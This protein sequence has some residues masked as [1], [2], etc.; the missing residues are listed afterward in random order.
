MLV[1]FVK[2][3]F[4]V[5]EPSVLAV[6]L[7]IQGRTLVVERLHQAP[8]IM[9]LADLVIVRLAL[10]DV[11]PDAEATLISLPFTSLI[12]LTMLVLSEVADRK[13]VV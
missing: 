9:N 3:R 5:V 8:T 1:A 12:A 13:S 10:A 11:V 6:L 7:S 4:H 2:C